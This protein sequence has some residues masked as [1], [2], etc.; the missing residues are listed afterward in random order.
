MEQ[1]KIPLDQSRSTRELGSWK[2][3]AHYLGV[4]VRTAQKWERERGLPVRRASGVRGR[5]SA[6]TSALD[7]W[8]E[9]GRQLEPQQGWFQWPLAP[10]L[11]VEL[12]FV[13]RKPKA[14]DVELFREYLRLLQ[15]AFSGPD[16][17]R[18]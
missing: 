4:N 12:R 11:A 8:R 17:V 1:K 9:H 10:D 14:A 3:I 6:D 18:T 5:V 7:A 15:R 16:S 13:G 2:A